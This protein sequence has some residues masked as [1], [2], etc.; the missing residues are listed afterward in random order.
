MQLAG[1]LTG[2]ALAAYTAMVSTEALNYEKVKK[3]VLH[4]YDVNEETH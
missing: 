3:V 4:R 2:K 1:L